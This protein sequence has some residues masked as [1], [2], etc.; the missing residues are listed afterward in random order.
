MLGHRLLGGLDYRVHFT[1]EGG[2]SKLPLGRGFSSAPH[3]VVAA[4]EAV[5]PQ[6]HGSAVVIGVNG[7][8]QECPPYIFSGWCDLS[9]GGL[10]FSVAWLSLRG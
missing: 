2:P 7:G 4:L 8:G 6:R 1:L 10:G 3:S 9:F 5:R